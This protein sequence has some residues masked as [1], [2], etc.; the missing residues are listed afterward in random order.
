MPDLLVVFPGIHQT[1]S[2]EQT[3][4]E[5]GVQV[6]LVPTPP[7]LRT[8]CGFSLLVSSGEELAVPPWWEGLARQAVVYRVVTQEGQRKYEEVDRRK[9][10]GVPPAGDPRQKSPGGGKPG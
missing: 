1:L 2:A 6:I 7:G 8:G 4:K 3:L 5:K 10:A 9:G